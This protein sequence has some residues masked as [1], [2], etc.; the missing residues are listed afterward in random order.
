MSLSVA[1]ATLASNSANCVWVNTPFIRIGELGIAGV[2]ER[3]DSVTGHSKSSSRSSLNSGGKCPSRGRDTTR[4]VTPTDNCRQQP[5]RFD[6]SSRYPLDRQ[7]DKLLSF[8][9]NKP[10]DHL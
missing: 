9:A 10:M 1:M 8:P 3:H 5:D 2:A 6:P 7:Q 4:R